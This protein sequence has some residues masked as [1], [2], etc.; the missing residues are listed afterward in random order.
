MTDVR[1]ASARH[2]C[3]LVGLVFVMPGSLVSAEEK[4]EPVPPA[5]TE[6]LLPKP[7]SEAVL[8]RAAQAEAEATAGR[9]NQNAKKPG[10]RPE[11]Q[12]EAG[13]VHHRRGSVLKGSLL[14]KLG[15]PVQEQDFS[16]ALDRVAA[17][18][19]Q[20]GTD[21]S[22]PLAPTAPSVDELQLAA[23]QLRVIARSLESLAADHEDLGQYA[24]ADRL[25]A[26]VQRLRH[27][28]RTLSAGPQSCTNSLLLPASE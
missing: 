21:H 6:A 14:E 3:L 10:D 11:W 26:A 12:I 1:F 23:G 15:G 2:C 13:T 27:E 22:L 9:P 8:L 25:R 20:T 16:A 17:A 7:V 4:T 24:E 5:S 18:Q 19:R 28:A